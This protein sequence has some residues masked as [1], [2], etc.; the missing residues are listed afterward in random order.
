MVLLELDP[1]SPDK[2]RVITG[3]RA[4]RGVE[5]LLAETEGD[6]DGKL[7]VED[8]PVIDL[9]EFVLASKDEEGSRLGDRSELKEPNS[10]GR[11]DEEADDAPKRAGPDTILV[12]GVVDVGGVVDGEREGAVVDDCADELALSQPGDA[13]DARRSR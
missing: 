5:L 8:E 9:A 12:R 10:A 4:V 13:E 3:G 2:L 6:T 11:E 1:E 7:A